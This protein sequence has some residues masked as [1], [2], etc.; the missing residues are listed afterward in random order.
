MTVEIFQEWFYTFHDEIFSVLE[1]EK[2]ADAGE[3]N[4]W[5]KIEADAFLTLYALYKRE[6]NSINN[7]LFWI[8]LPYSFYFPSLYG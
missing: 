5:E 8:P 4:N 1:P 7:I 3:C 6:M 2:A